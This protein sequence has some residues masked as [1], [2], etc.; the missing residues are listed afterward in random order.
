M[1]RKP[2]YVE[3][4]IE[5]P[6]EE[7]WVHTQQPEL[8]QQWDLRFTEIN[9][10]PREQE[11]AEQHFQYRTRI[12]FGLQ[13]EGTGITTSKEKA[14]K[15]GKETRL[16]TLSFRSEQAMS[17]I[18]QG[19]GYW[20]YKPEGDGIVKFITL[21]DY[22][23]R[24]GLLGKLFDTAVFRPLF[25]FA[26]AWSFDRLR[27]WLE[28][29]IPPSVTAGRAL[30]HYTS[31]ITLV[32]LWFYM[33]LVP[34]LFY[35]ETSGEFDIMQ[36]TGMFGGYEVPM[37]RVLGVL[38]LFLGLAA[39]IGHRSAWSSIL[40]A[41]LLLLLTVPICIVYPEMLQSPFNP[42]TVSLPMLACCFAAYKTRNFL[43]SAA[44]CIRKPPA[45]RKS[46]RGK[47]HEVHI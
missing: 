40:Q 19:G 16:S 43:P 32:S 26:T 13:I 47:V 22:Q 24:F 2:I 30:V 33:G 37:I 12:G 27:I 42:V 1:K 36:H 23:T 14:G 21:Y 15:D 28:H 20:S 38:E 25:G 35:T 4:N 5:A 29:R 46:G 6:L 9:Y 17:L 18:S 10:L 45:T 41:A 44:R 34:K 7:L 3:L 31:V 11:E 8:H 39:A